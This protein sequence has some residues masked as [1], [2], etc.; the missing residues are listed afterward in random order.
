VID[1]SI[2]QKKIISGLPKRPENKIISGLPK[3]PTH[4][5]HNPP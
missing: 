2:R 5:C 3:R 4:S 1:H